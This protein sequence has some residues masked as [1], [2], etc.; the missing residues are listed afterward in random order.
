MFLNYLGKIIEVPRNNF[1]SDQ[2]YK[3]KC[4]QIAKS[5]YFPFTHG[6]KSLYESYGMT[7]SI[8]NLLKT[9][10]SSSDILTSCMKM[11]EFRK[12][13][14]NYLSLYFPKEDP[15]K[16]MYY[17]GRGRSDSDIFSI[18]SEYYGNKSYI[19]MNLSLILEQIP[20]IPI[21][22]DDS[23]LY[24]N[25]WNR[26]K[27]STLEK[28]KLLYDKTYDIIIIDRIL[29]TYEN[30]SLLI[31]KCIPLLNPGALLVIYDYDYSGTNE[32]LIQGID[33]ANM[34]LS[35][36][37]IKNLYTNIIPQLQLQ[38]SIRFPNLSYI[39]IIN[40]E[41]LLP[42][43]MIYR[44]QATIDNKFIIEYVF[45][46]N[47][48]LKE[49]FPPI[50]NDTPLS[51]LIEGRNY[52]DEYLSM[53]I[54]YQNGMK[55]ANNI[56]NWAKSV[57]PNFHKYNFIDISGR[58]NSYISGFMID[59]FTQKKLY[60][61]NI[62]EPD[63]KYSKYL[64]NNMKIYMNQ[65][66]KNK[67]N[68]VMP[69]G[70]MVYLQQRPFNENTLTL[71]TTKLNYDFKNTVVFLRIPNDQTDFKYGNLFL[72][73]YIKLLFRYKIPLIIIQMDLNYKF[74]IKH[75]KQ[76]KL[77]NTQV[78]GIIE[79]DIYD[80]P[81][82]SATTIPSITKIDKPISILQKPKLIMDVGKVV[83]EILRT[84]ILLN[85]IQTL[86]TTKNLSYDISSDNKF[87]EYLYQC[88][89]TGK[90]LDPVIPYMSEPLKIISMDNPLE[91]ITSFTKL[92]DY[93]NKIKNQEAYK[94]NEKLLPY[95]NNKQ[96][97]VVSTQAK[98]KSELSKLILSKSSTILL[99]DINNIIKNSYD[100]F[101]QQK[102]IPN[103]SCKII[104]NKN[105]LTIEPNSNL[106]SLLSVKSP[107]RNYKLDI[108]QDDLNKFKLLYKGNT[109]NFSIDLAALLLRYISLRIIYP[110]SVIDKYNQLDKIY[111]FTNQI[112]LNGLYSI[113]DSYISYNN[114]LE[115]LF[116]GLF[117][118]IEIDK[119]DVGSYYINIPNIQ[120]LYPLITR[121]L[122]ILDSEI[123]YSFVIMVPLNDIYNEIL[124][125]LINSKHIKNNTKDENYNIIVL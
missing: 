30:Q 114:D 125:I 91:N 66:D 42:Y 85:L 13:L 48:L 115:K 123:N 71:L 32:L 3:F 124:N 55:L 80:R 102:N 76:F 89:S 93:W 22:S 82:E 108:Q 81:I 104:L 64:L 5:K 78:V 84:E 58:Y 8:D 120:L 46:K 54:K 97:P 41:S 31:E 19:P 112:I 105:I 35:G 59:D 4:E 121:I 33:I 103:L 110:K 74:N 94:N 20:H 15:E 116:G 70:L 39:N 79:S 16:L 24:L 96:E 119:L 100:L 75:S 21:Q 1:E 90:V 61:V 111:K 122:N 53:I 49:L 57:L 43:H 98:F 68:F 51:Q 10:T 107:F 12:I 52:D 44:K 86:L 6:M 69:N 83:Y 87:Y 27:V 106:L 56:T 109:D 117:N 101:N 63:P 37:I 36:N 2:E 7:F 88:I 29:H 34:A 25:M 9:N 45:D 14:I 60:N 18:V 28:S 11:S 17:F 65:P 77:D 95:L 62:Y 23:I 118:I 38:S 72:I 40:S 113:K 92:R 47:K 67:L 26:P 73:D 50:I 99:T